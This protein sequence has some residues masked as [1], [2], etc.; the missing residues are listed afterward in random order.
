MYTIRR[1]AELTGVREPTLRAW[2]R[3]YGVLAPT[4]SEAGYRLYDDEDLDRIRAMQALVQVGWAPR[5]AAQEVLRRARARAAAASQQAGDVPFGPL[6]R[7]AADLD[8]AA[9]RRIV[10]E[11]FRR[12][13]FEEVVDDWLMPALYAIGDDWAAGRLSVVGEHLVAHAAHRQLAAA[14]DAAARETMA[15]AVLVGLP[16]EAV[17]ELGAFAFAVAARRA[18]LA[19]TYLGSLPAPE[20]LVA[21]ERERAA[22]VVLAVPREA[23][24][25]AL[26]E[27]VDALQHAAPLVRIAA[28]G[29]FQDQAPEPTDPLGHR[30]GP[31]A[32]RLARM[33][34]AASPGGGSGAVTTRPSQGQRR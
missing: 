9:V 21:V 15:P 14:Y 34:A 17:H 22:C 27:V 10:E 1:V 18:G 16:G 4:R 11:Q 26:A 3:R 7:A 32:D 19:A 20:W 25:A 29:R 31:A 12:G 5:Q 28:G 13:S 6:R 33:L 8:E 2:E 23:H 24:L 30:I